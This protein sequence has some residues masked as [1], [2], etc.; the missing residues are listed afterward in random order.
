MQNVIDLD[1][2]ERTVQDAREY[3]ESI[4]ETVRGPLIVLDADLKVISG[5]RTFYQIFNTKPKK[6]EG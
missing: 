5:N 4:V 3:A 6:T 2:N 1:P